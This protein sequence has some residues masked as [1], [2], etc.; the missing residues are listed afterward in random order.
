MK[1]AAEN[2]KKRMRRFLVLV[3]LFKSDKEDEE[4]NGFK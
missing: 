4:F 1:Y 3:E 2:G